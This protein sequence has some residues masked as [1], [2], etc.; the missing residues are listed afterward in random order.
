MRS[1]LVILPLLTL[2]WLTSINPARAQVSS[3]GTLS[4]TVTSPDGS[5]FTI[6]NG[7][8]AGGNLFHSFSQFSVPNG[9]SAVFQ[10]PTDVQNIISRV[11]GGAIS[12][13]DGLIR[14]QG[15]ANLFLLN[16]TGIVFGPN[17]SLNIGGSFFATTA[18]S[19]L[20]GD[21]VEFSATNLQ[22]P[23]VLSVNI[24]IGLRFR[25]NP[26][27]ITNQ[28]IAV[29]NSGNPVGLQVQKGNSLA[30]VG[31]DVNLLDGGRLTAAGGRIELGGLAQAGT[32]GLE[33][34][35]NTFRLNFPSNILLS[36]VTLA[37]DARVAVR[38]NGGGDIA[39]NTSIF[40][41]T[42]GGRLVG[43]IEGTATKKGGDITV[44]SN[45]FN[46]SGVGRSGLGAGIYQ[47]LVANASGDAGNINI[48][49]N[50]FNA[51]LDARVENNILSGGRGSAGDINI[52]AKSLSL[53]ND[54]QVRGIVE[55]GGNGKA[56]NINIQVG[57]LLVTNGSQISTSLF[58]PFGD[59][60]GAQGSAGNIQVNASDSVTLSGYGST[61]FSSGLL[62]LAERETFGSAGNIT[63]TTSNFRIT[64]GAFIT[65][66]TFNSTSDAGD[67]TINAKNFEAL[68]GG[69]LLTT[70]RTSGKAGNIKLNVT[71]KITLSASDSNFA[72][73]VAQVEQRL[74]SNPG[75][76]DV[77]SDVVKNQGAVSGL[78]AI[79][80]LNSTGN[81]GSI[82]ISNPV[83]LAITDGNRIA[84]DSRGGGNAGDLQI[85]A[86]KITLDRGALLSAITA[87]G[88]GGNIALRSQD[89]LLLRNNSQI[90]TTAGTTGTGGDGGNITIDTPF[91]VAF[92]L[93]NSDITANAFRGSGGKIV[94]KTQGLFGINPLSQQDLEKLRPQDLDP[95]KLQTNDITAISQQNPTL[96]GTVEINTPDVDPSQGLVELPEN[97]TDPTDQIAQ[98]PCQKGAGS[99][100]TIIGRGGLP[101]SPN[102]SFN[103]DNVRV[104][105]VKPS[106][107][108]SNSQSSNINQPTTQPTAK[109][110]IPAQG[111]IFNNKGEVVLTAYDPNTTNPQRTSK[112]TAA[113][114]APF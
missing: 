77:L 88:K 39:V 30:L 21:G 73:R 95:N 105:L 107:T 16:P 68:N 10:N 61:G 17:A 110:I 102:E 87:S 44:K 96:S 99:S 33:T 58:R 56:S 31:G 109:Q 67:I 84:V 89:F 112:S 86:D 2:G 7:D 13:I 42:N 101:S 37:N 19:L 70:T 93:E 62:A 23:P 48:N 24:P 92:P 32:V 43:G 20:F 12:N 52:T 85:Q 94:I 6:D 82:I 35:S 111:W 36:N 55:A 45:E 59:R 71:D 113:C 108:S 98:N 41:A 11:T 53:T 25:D 106:T 38:G 54:A 90:S 51:S 60:P 3:D 79:T 46:I 14:T 29:D 97:L 63:V 103:S 18:N 74:K 4:T 57:S 1:L 28:S 83:E 15:S 40:T 34:N 75:N 66:S 47:Q 80:E 72:N 49:T 65:V 104:D 69:Q 9:G 26:G 64:D 76:T 91:I 22:T 50:F 81:G 5:N 8:R 100:F 27:D 78:F 114:P